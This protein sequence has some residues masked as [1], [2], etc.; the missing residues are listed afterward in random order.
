MVELFKLC[1]DSKTP[2]TRGLCRPRKRVPKSAAHN[3]KVPLDNPRKI[4]GKIGRTLKKIVR[5]S[6]SIRLC[7]FCDW[8]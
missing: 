2:R 1:K 5:F 6:L 3:Q 4:T 8:L 7:N